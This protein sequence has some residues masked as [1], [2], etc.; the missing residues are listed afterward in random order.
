MYQRSQEHVAVYDHNTEEMVHQ[1]TCPNLQTSL[2]LFQFC[3]FIKKRV[4]LVCSQYS[5]LILFVLKAIK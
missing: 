2:K 1:L 3:L 5:Q 4:A